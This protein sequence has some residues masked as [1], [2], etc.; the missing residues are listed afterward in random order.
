MQVNFKKVVSDSEASK[1]YEMYAHI[2]NS[3]ALYIHSF[4]YLETL[5][6]H[7]KYVRFFSTAFVG[8]IFPLR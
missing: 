3:G 1:H 8:N 2:N 7:I 5:G 6:T 4:N